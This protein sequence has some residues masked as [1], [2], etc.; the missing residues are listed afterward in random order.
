MNE[1]DIDMVIDIGT[2]AAQEAMKK[3]Y[4]IIDTLPDSNMKGAALA[5]AVG[6]M[7]VRMETIKAAAVTDGQVRDLINIVSEKTRAFYAKKKESTAN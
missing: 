4:D 6:V 5:V 2:H 3:A 1:R 7:E